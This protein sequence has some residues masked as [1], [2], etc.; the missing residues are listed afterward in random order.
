MYVGP[1]IFEYA[2]DFHGLY[3]CNS[4]GLGKWVWNKLSV[5]I[6]MKTRILIFQTVLVK[7]KRS[8]SDQFIYTL[9]PYTTLYII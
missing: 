1:N 8:I 3:K 7:C 6:L 2:R 4:P 5:C 9:L